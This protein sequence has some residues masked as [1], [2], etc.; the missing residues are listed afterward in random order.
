MKI[1]WVLLDGLGDRSCKALND[2]T[3]LQA[4]VTPHLDFLAQ[5]GSNGLYHAS[6]P[7]QCLPSEA[8]HFL[9][10]GYSLEEFPG[11]ALL[12][13]VG[14]RVSF[15]DRD[16]LF[17]AHLCNATWQEGI[18]FLRLGR[19]AIEHTPV[20]L[21][22][23]YGAISPHET[24][25][26]RFR[27]EQTRPNDGILIA[28]GGA[29]PWVSDSDPM[30]AGRALARIHALSE[31]SETGSA[32]KTAGALNRFLSRCHRI[33][34]DH[35]V[36][37][38]RR[39]NGLPPANF[40][41]TLRSGRRVRQESFEKRWGFRGMVIASGAVFEGLAHELGLTFVQAQ[42][43]NDPGEDLRARIHFALE[44]RQHDFI[45]VH[46]KAADEAA[47]SGDPIRKREVIAGLDSGLVDLV[48]A[49]KHREDLLVAVGSDHSTPSVSAMIHSGET[50][51]VTLV[52][53][54]VRRDRITAF[55]EVSAAAGC[56]GTLRGKELLLTLLNYAD[57]S[58][59]RGHR[60]GPADGEYFPT[61]YEPFRLTD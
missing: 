31:T 30:V 37:Q 49:V 47:H 32:E 56:L 3:P 10:F 51:P 27:L 44:D 46:T 42:D 26:I 59:L 22:K 13:A 14:K 54:G 4:A 6:D 16:V 33:L 17:M 1:I 8:A 2:R 38:E 36:N 25:G 23:L 48:Q 52:G 45:H 9:M 19:K 15:D 29:S 58:I 55:D 61:A 60:L 21:E 39:D 12:E 20:G 11:R 57:R 35:P 24:D 53:P 40:L 34:R 5:L 50:V 41:V 43:R 7:G 28:T 18:P